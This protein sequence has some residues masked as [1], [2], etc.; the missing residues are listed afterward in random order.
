MAMESMS[1]SN[2]REL[3]S[4][5]S[6]RQAVLKAEK[7]RGIN[8]KNFTRQVD[9]RVE[10][11][12]SSDRIKESEDSS[13]ETVVTLPAHGGVVTLPTGG[14]GVILPTHGGNLELE[15]EIDNLPTQR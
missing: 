12:Q 15:L 1:N 7:Q 5:L 4:E 2:P 13:V 9:V 3:L 6:K 14:G 11:S 10:I 8:D